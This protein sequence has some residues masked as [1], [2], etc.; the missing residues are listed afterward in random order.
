VKK[1]ISLI[2]LSSILFINTGYYLYFTYLRISI[3]SYIAQ[4][5]DNGVE[6]KDLK[7]IVISAENKHNIIWIKKDKELKYN[8]LMYDVVRVKFKK[9]EKYYYCI[10]DSQETQLVI[11][12]TKTN[13]NL[14]KIFNNLKKLLNNKYFPKSYIVKT[15][16][17]DSIKYFNVNQ[18]IKHFLFQDILTP[19]PQ[20]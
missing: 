12:F 13:K 15:F 3:H 18:V 2:L 14:N 1:V 9:G 4:K 10:A 5:I 11:N 8:N 20:L 17:S 16:L 19:P 6:S 7:L